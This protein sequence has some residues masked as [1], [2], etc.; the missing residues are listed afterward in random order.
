MSI[1]N[2]YKIKYS[3]NSA[4][5][6]EDMKDFDKMLSKF[7]FIRFFTTSGVNNALRSQKNCE[8]FIKKLRWRTS[9]T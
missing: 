3:K 1:S 5:L 7:N 2:Y 6:Y 9:E 4:V 8:S